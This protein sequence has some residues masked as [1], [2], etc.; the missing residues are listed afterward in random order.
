M[1]VLKCDFAKTLGHVELLGAV[2][3]LESGK[4]NFLPIS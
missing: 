4:V 2:F 3:D 1:A